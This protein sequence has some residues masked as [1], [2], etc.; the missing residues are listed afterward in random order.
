MTLRPFCQTLGGRPASRRS[1]Q[2]D[3]D[4]RNRQEP[5]AGENRGRIHCVA[6][7]RA[8]HLNATRYFFV[9]MDPKLEIADLRRYSSYPHST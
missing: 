7:D 4:V 1:S 6:R 8:T 5:P 2:F 9:A 3:T